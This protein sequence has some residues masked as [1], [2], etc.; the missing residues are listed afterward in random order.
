MQTTVSDT[1][2]FPPQ[3]LIQPVVKDHEQEKYEKMWAQ[4]AYRDFSPG[5]ATAMQFLKVARPSKMDK[6]IDF[7]CGTGRGSLMLALLG[8]L[9]VTMVD[10]TSNSL[11]EDVYNMLSSQKHMMHFVQADLRKP[12]DVYAKYG[13]CTD[14]MEH[15]PPE[16]VDAALSHILKS[17]QHVY[18]QISTVPDH[19]G[20]LIGEQLHLTVQPYEWWREKLK[21]LDAIINWSHYDDNTASFYVTAWTKGS[22]LVQYGSVNTEHE[23]IKAQVKINSAKGYTE[24]VP[25]EKQG[26]PVMILAGGPSMNDYVGE[27]IEKRKNGMKLVTVNNAYNWAL[28]HSLEPSAQIMV[29]A[30]E[31]NKRFISRV[32]PDCKYM[33]ASQ[34]HPAVFESIPKEQVW[35]WHSALSED[36]VR[37]IEELKGPNADPWYPVIGGSTVMLRALPLLF[38]LGYSKFDIYGFDSCILNGEHHAYKQEENDGITEL[39][40][41]CGGRVFRTHPW[42]ASQAQEF[43]DLMQI[44][45]EHIEL[46]VHGDGLIAHVIR[47]AAETGDVRLDG[48]AVTV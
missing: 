9:D 16:D 48:S 14:V 13:Y 10:F 17:A 2:G 28:E 42:M 37:Y 23:T 47:V 1:I 44:M 26:T 15:L 36:L 8:N 32:V 40:T 7:G 24:V 3:V 25:F 35:M 43:L 11:D 4:P 29:D 45:A 18:F 31:F 34:C 41:I 20:S 27:I 30:R 33:L 46:Q 38:M 39:Q 12:M 22:E 6:V 19:M 5:E 21:S